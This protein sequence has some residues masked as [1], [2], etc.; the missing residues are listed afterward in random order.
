MV[1]TRYGL[2]K[3]RTAEVRRGCIFHEELSSVDGVIR[4]GG[5]IGSGAKFVSPT[6][7]FRFSGAAGGRISYGDVLRN[8]MT[9]ITMMAWFKC[10]NSVATRMTI[11]AHNTNATYYQGI[12]ITNGQLRYN[13]YV[14]GTTRSYAIAGTYNDGLWHLA[15]FTWY[16]TTG[17]K[18]YVD[19]V[20]ISTTGGTYTGT[21]A[22]IA[23]ADNLTIGASY[24]TAGEA[25]NFK[26]NIKNAMVFNTALDADEIAAYYNGSMFKYDDFCVCDLPFDI[27]H[28]D[29]VNKRSLDV[30]GYNNHATWGD[31][32]TSTT[33]P[34]KLA[35]S[36][37]YSFDGG[38]YMR[39]PILPTVKMSSYIMLNRTTIGNN[40]LWGSVGAGYILR[41]GCDDTVTTGGMRLYVGT[42]AALVAPLR[43]TFAPLSYCMRNDQAAKQWISE[44][45]VEI[46]KDTSATRNPINGYP[47]CLGGLN[48]AGV[49]SPYMRGNIYTF[50]HYDGIF[51][52]TMQCMDLDI[53]TKECL[54]KC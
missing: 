38:D 37:G 9:A 13:I 7:G 25:F 31:S 32:V 5:V 2:T 46:V 20:Y 1:H 42:G 51:L 45:G 48:I 52:N 34:T 22:P 53:R 49:W 17:I 4:N 3:L 36:R 44:N 18:A 29:T 10:D 16:S 30:S 21:T 12:E 40:S 23:G 11:L 39:T 35:N 27:A 14:G 54:S 50:K 47:I 15:T 19:G 26:G 6:E 28:H 41:W 33:F 43:N 8:P 24:C